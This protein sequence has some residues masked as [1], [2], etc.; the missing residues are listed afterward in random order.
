MTKPNAA[1]QE[2]IAS[3]RSNVDVARD[4]MNGPATTDSHVIVSELMLDIK[5][6][7]E[8]LQKKAGELAESGK[9]E[10]TNEIFETID[11]VSHLEPEFANWSSRIVSQPNE[12]GANIHTEEGEKKK[13]KKKKK[14][15]E[16]DTE[17]GE[18]VVGGGWEAFPAPQ[19][20]ESWPSNS[21]QP[22]TTHAVSFAA[23]PEIIP[24][25]GEQVKKASG[26]LALGM[27]WETIGPLL[28]DPGSTDEVRR[29]RLGELMKEAIAN[30]CGI[31]LDRIKIR[32]VC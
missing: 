22:E 18:V 12:I 24:P 16:S 2:L 5:Q 25:A 26:R 23:A 32:S 10:N 17:G 31:T 4:A 28:G 29:Q 14:R 9:F 6:S 1:V 20:P 13:K 30:E 11:M 19:Q 8:M 3:V 27:T 21:V 7:Q 15:K